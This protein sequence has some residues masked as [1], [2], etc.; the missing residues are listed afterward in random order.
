MQLFQIIIT[1]LRQHGRITHLLLSS[2]SVLGVGDMCS[3][4]ALRQGWG[5]VVLKLDWEQQ[6]S[7]AVGSFLE[8]SAGVSE[9]R[10]LLSAPTSPA[11]PGNASHSS[12]WQS[13]GHFQQTA[14]KAQKDHF[15]EL[16]GSGPEE[17]DWK[18]MLG[19]SILESVFSCLLCFVL[20]N[21]PYYACKK[22]I[23]VQC[24][25]NKPNACGL[26]NTLYNTVSPP[27]NTAT[28]DKYCKSKGGR[29]LQQVQ[30]K[31][32]LLTLVLL[33]PNTFFFSFQVKPL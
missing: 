24:M 8:A 1:C 22:H 19:D 27:I 33:P 12:S 7:P 15:V 16:S 2:G 29:L 4:R 6:M 21:T 5:R 17:I 3:N 10:G 31:M 28:H 11:A 14:G 23:L 26:D 30:L 32:Y 9:S 25:L 20:W 18:H 13:L